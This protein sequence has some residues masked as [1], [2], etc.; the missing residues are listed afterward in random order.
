MAKKPVKVIPFNSYE[1][2]MW[3]AMWPSPFYYKKRLFKSIEHMYQFYSLST[4]EK[5][6]RAKILNSFC[7]YKAKFH[8]SKKAGGKKRAEHETKRI[9]T[10]KIA[11]RESYLQNP[12]RLFALLETKDRLSHVMEGSSDWAVNSK[13]QGADMYGR[14]TTEFRDSMRDKDIWKLCREH[15]KLR[16]AEYNES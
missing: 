13:G 5:D 1:N 6:L 12:A 14:M 9:D 8:A 7:P 2:P 10:M 11:I 16:T 4:S 15:I 3:S